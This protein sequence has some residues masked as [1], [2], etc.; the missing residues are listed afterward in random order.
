[1]NRLELNGSLES[2]TKIAAVLSPACLIIFAILYF[3]KINSSNPTI[4]S[5]SKVFLALALLIFFTIFTIRICIKSHLWLLEKKDWIQ[6]LL[7]ILTVVTIT[8]SIR[9][10]NRENI[11]FHKLSDLNYYISENGLGNWIH[12]SV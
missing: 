4:V 6:W 10:C 3:E 7:L 12:H 1:M 8:M 11:S 5:S 9:M 2:L